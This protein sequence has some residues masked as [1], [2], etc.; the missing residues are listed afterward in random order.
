MES[1]VARIVTLAFGVALSPVPVVAVLVILL[2]ARARVGS[3]VFAS[4]WVLGNA[5]AITLATVFARR[6]TGP[7]PAFD[8]QSEGLAIALL[9]VALIVTALL[10]RL[11]RFR[12]RDP[13]ATPRWVTA[14]DNLS[15]AGGAVVA[16]TNA[17]T[18]PKNL[19]LALAA[20]LAIESAGRGIEVVPAALL[21]VG[22]ASVTVVT[23]VIV[24][25]LAGERA[26]PLIARWK[27]RI[28]RR[29][30]AILEIT[31]FVF[32]VALAA[33]GLYNLLA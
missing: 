2:T 6:V 3:V 13:S 18:S 11:A 21:Y 27:E 24:Y 7:L 14:V 25:F 29:A 22:V 32:G 28:S 15:P 5:V 4:S 19:A 12:S 26:T 23:P 17:T 33:R 10:S 31:L 30:A 1:L 8:L 20:G 9:G 16:F